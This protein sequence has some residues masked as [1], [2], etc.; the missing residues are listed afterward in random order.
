M[1]SQVLPLELRPDLR[2]SVLTR[3]RREG[4]VPGIV[5]G[6]GM[7]ALPVAVEA[8]RLAKIQ[9]GQGT[10]LVDLEVPGRGRVPAVIQEVQRDPITRKVLH[11]DFHVVSL[12]E[13]V[14][15]EIPVV[16]LGVDAVEKKGLVVQQQLR[17]VEIRCLPARLPEQLTVDVSSAEAGDAVR[18]GDVAL[19]E[20]AVLLTDPDAVLLNVSES[21]EEEGEEVP[22]EEKES[23]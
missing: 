10:A 8:S 13:P 14:D 1:R 21:G 6:R 18:A 16:V 15:V 5:Y 3:L 23:Q 2:R 11:V 4:R 12:D 7:E 22:E 20:G 9:G 19:P 17:H